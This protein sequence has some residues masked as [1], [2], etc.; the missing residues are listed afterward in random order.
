MNL[1]STLPTR[2]APIGPRNGMSE[3]VRATE[4]ALIAATSGSFSVSAESTKAM[5]WVSHLK[6]SANSGRI[7]RSIMRWSRFRARWD[8]LRA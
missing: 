5:T 8:G 1:P 3:R 6:P 4:A 2:T 7:G